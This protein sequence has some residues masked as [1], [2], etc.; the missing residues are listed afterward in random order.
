[1]NRFSGGGSSSI[2]IYNINYE[3][4]V[5]GY[6]KGL[7][8]N[9]KIKEQNTEILAQSEELQTA[10]DKLIEL[11]QF[12]EELTGMI[13]HDLKNPLNAII[14]LSENDIV[15]QSGKQMLNMIMNILDVNKFENTE[16]KIQ[17]S[18]TSVNEVSKSA[19]QQVDLLYHQKSIKLI[20]RIQNY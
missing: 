19:L 7:K 12:K 10:N 5:Q 1:M 16:I 17:T 14:G 13:I 6:S 3:Q 18:N 8:V 11:D 2:N 15:K 4:T 20:N 9:D